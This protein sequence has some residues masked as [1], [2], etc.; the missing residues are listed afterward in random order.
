MSLSNAEGLRKLLETLTPNQ[1]EAAETCEGELLIDAGAG[2]GKTL[3]IIARIAVLLSKGASPRS[4]LAATFS[5]AAVAQIETKLRQ[6]TRSD[7]RVCTLHA[8]A[9]RILQRKGAV[10]VCNEA[11][12]LAMV[13]QAA[14]GSH[15]SAQTA[16]REISAAKNR[17]ENPNSLRLLDT[18]LDPAAVAA[19]WRTYEK[20]K[21]SRLDFDDLLLRAIEALQADS[22]LLHWCHE[23]YRHITVDE[24]QDTNPLQWT[25]IRSVYEGRIVSLR[26]PCRLD[27]KGRTIAVVGDP[28]QAIYAFRGGDVNL[29]LGFAVEYPNAKVVQLGENFR[30]QRL[31]VSAAAAVISHN[32]RRTPKLLAARD[33]LGLPLR[34]VEVS[35]QDAIPRAVSMI[36]RGLWKRTGGK[37]QIA[38]LFR[39]NAELETL[40]TSVDVPVRRTDGVFF[41]DLPEV[42]GIAALVNA[43]REPRSDYWLWEASRAVLPPERRLPAS[44]RRRQ[45]AQGLALWDVLS[46]NEDEPEAVSVRNAVLATIA[47][48]CHGNAR[49]VTE[50][51]RQTGWLQTLQA[52]ASDQARSRLEE[53][54]SRVLGPGDPLKG[55]VG[56]SEGFLEVMTVHKSKG[57]EREY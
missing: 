17:G 52:G 24:F 27:H 54:S 5:R 40:R 23:T 48:G 37:A 44:L 57:L 38:A 36:C 47:A 16:L 3:T 9:Q 18:R 12:T 29:I 30:S 49:Q 19:I 43:A 50:A 21:G 35:S 51:A 45:H 42:R 32:S 39:H 33:S 20:E 46:T 8:W 22:E 7:V 28:D 4:V 53:F 13:N 6:I 55:L 14:K 41:E 10:R 25:L 1:R 56:E 26:S 31:V 34:L 2:S 11:A 15:V